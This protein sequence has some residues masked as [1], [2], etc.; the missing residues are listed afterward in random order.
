MSSNYQSTT[1]DPHGGKTGLDRAVSLA[2]RNEVE[3]LSSTRW[4]E[5]LDELALSM[6]R[7][8]DTFEKAFS[9]AVSTYKGAL[10]LNALQASKR[11]ERTGRL[12]PARKHVNKAASDYA[13]ISD[14]RK[15][16]T[17]AQERIDAHIAKLREVDPSLSYEGAFVKAWSHGSPVLGDIVAVREIDAQLQLREGDA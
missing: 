4:S 6:Q 8:G 10:L 1:F 11:Y 12:P 7:D 17:T 9:R 14:L 13:A 3:A 16:K 15:K 2:K 5:H